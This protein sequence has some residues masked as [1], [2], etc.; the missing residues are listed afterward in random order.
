MLQLLAKIIP[1]DLAAT[2]SPVILALTVL[3]LASKKDKT[4]KVVGFLLGNLLSGIVYTSLGFGL[5]KTV[6]SGSKETLGSAIVDLVLALLF[7]GYGFKVLLAKD[8]DKK[9]PEETSRHPFLKWFLIG[10]IITVTNFDA[11]F[12]ILAAAKEVGAAS[13]NEFLKWLLLALNLF[14]YLLPVSL[15]VFAYLIFP[16]FANRILAA[17]NAFMIKYARLIVFLLFAVFGIYFLVKG[18]G[19]FI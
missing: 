8:K 13:I 5:G 11:D 9:P 4:A 17:I 18:M 1:L 15:P 7:I 2:L 3:L 12:L 6:S 16:K 10:A 14:F 19:Y